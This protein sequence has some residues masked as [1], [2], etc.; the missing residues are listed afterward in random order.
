MRFESIKEWKKIKLLNE[1]VNDLQDID[2]T[3][4]IELS[5]DVKSSI[6]YIVNCAISEGLPKKQTINYIKSVYQDSSK[7]PESVS[8][9]I[10]RE[11]LDIIIEK[12][13][14]IYH[15]PS[16]SIYLKLVESIKN[17]DDIVFMV[18]GA[19]KVYNKNKLYDDKHLQFLQ[20][21]KAVLVYKNIKW[22]KEILK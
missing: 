21:S 12:I 7:A 15:W 9:S 19:L 5:D 1:S 8:V 17:E 20:E 4:N 3:K 16:E 11:H 14:K 10:V 22:V 13:N 2:I 6:D 18:K